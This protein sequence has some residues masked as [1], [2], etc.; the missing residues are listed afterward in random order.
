MGWIRKQG[1]GE[2]LSRILIQGLKKKHGIPDLVTTRIVM[3][4]NV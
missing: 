3:L 1:S 2:D 4:C